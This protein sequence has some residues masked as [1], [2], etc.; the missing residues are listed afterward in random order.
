MPRGIRRS[1][2]RLTLGIPA[3]RTRM[4]AV[5][6]KSF[7]M[8]GITTAPLMIVETF[9]FW[10]KIMSEPWFTAFET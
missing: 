8:L 10:T 5:I 3:W 7:P 2:I 9:T 1:M 4:R 6:A